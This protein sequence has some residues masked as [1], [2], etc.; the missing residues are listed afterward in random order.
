MLKGPPIDT[1][2]VERLGV[3]IAQGRYPIDPERIAAALC[4]EC[5]DLPS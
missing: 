5:F 4:R 3:E 1:A 2:T